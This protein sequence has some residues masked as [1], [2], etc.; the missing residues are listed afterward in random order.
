[1]NRYSR[2]SALTQIG[3]EGQKKIASARVAIVGLG[4]LGS[5]S[6]QLCARAGIGFLKLIDRDIV[7]KTNL[8]RQVLFTESDA[9][10]G[11]AKSTA[12]KDHLQTINSEIKIEA[13]LE[14]LRG[15]N[16]AELLRDVDA[17]LDGTDNFETRYLINDFAVKNKIPYIYGGA[18]ETRSMVYSVLPDGRPCLRCLFPQA[19]TA[20]SAQTC[21]RSGILASASHWTAALQFTQLVRYLTQGAA[22]IEPVLIQQDVW[23]EEV[24]RIQAAEFAAERCE[25]CRNGIFAALHSQSGTQTLKLCG[26]NAVQIQPEP[27]QGIISWNSLSERWKDRGQVL[28]GTDFARATFEH[29][30]LTLFKNGRVIIKGTEDPALARSLYARWVGC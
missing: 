3:D 19:P 28:V 18:I 21:D 13:V 22:S 1:M 6:A 29:Y 20:D 8:Q 23:S 4:A 27:G 5:V 12:S 14:D 30:E 15:E 11:R 2:Q 17:V 16:I 7:E 26:R 10:E 9:N 25:G 24:K